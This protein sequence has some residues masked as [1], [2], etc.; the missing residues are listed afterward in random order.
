MVTLVIV[1]VTSVSSLL[2]FRSRRL[3]S[4]MELSPYSIIR[5][6]EYHRLITHAFLHADYVH[7]IINMVVLYFFG[8]AV[9]SKFR[10]LE[11]QGIIFS[12]TFFFVLL[13]FGSIVLSTV[14]T[15]IKYRSNP[16]YGAVGASGA[17]SAIIFTYIFFAPLEK[18]YFY[19]VLPIPGIVFG[20]LYLI[21]SSIMT[22]RS[23]DNINH[24]A[25]FWGAVFGFIFPVLVEPE[26][27]K[28]FWNSFF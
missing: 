14:S 13:Y 25:H 28:I 19:M 2:A 8:T 22:R 3:F 17:V 10:G 7:L 5:S 23:K 11:E 4:G 27:I 26:L 16:G 21:Y 15:V 24:E 18:I 6:G 9:E 1:V 20:V 12:G